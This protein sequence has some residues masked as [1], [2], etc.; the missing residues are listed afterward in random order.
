MLKLVLEK[1]TWYKDTP[2]SQDSIIINGVVTS[3]NVGGLPTAYYLFETE[4]GEDIISESMNYVGLDNHY[5]KRI[6]INYISGQVKDQI[7]LPTGAM[8]DTIP[9]DSGEPESFIWGYDH[10]YPIAR[11]VNAL[12][13]FHTSFE[14]ETGTVDQ[15]SYTGEKVRSG[16]YTISL[17]L[18]DGDYVL[19][20][21]QRTS[22]TW[23]WKKEMVEVTGDS[24]ERTV[25]PETGADAIDEIRIH[26]VDALMTTYTFKP[27]VGMTSMTDAGGRVTRYVFDIHGRLLYIRD[28]EGNITQ[29]HEYHYQH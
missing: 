4:E 14:D 5:K 9:Q 7:K 11:T 16:S 15:D 8:G 22:G 2:F 21:C 10:N 6:M 13:A 3:Y 19:S 17:F 12:Q 20:Y 26:P 25:T 1:Q 18:S 29:S 23:E 28:H 27:L 24:Y